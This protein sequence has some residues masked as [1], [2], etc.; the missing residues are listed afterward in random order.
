MS[1][2]GNS[3]SYVGDDN[4]Y[5]GLTN[6]YVGLTNSYTDNKSYATWHQD[7]SIVSSK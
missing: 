3:N 7:T 2:V 4:T 5:E 6:T 1:Y